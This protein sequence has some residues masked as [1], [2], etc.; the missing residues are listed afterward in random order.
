MKLTVLVDNNTTIDK[1]YF[2]E[3]GLSYYIEEEGKRLLFDVGYSDIFLRNASKM[4]IDLKKT[5]YLVLSH[6][7]LDHTW[8]MVNLFGILDYY[9]GADSL[10][11]TLLAHPGSLV[12]KIDKGEQIGFIY[13]RQMVE[14]AFN[15]NLTKKTVWITEKLVFLGEIE[16]TNDFENTEPIG[17]TLDNGV[18]V[19]DYIMDDTALAYK[20]RE[21]IVVITGCSHSGICNI[22]EY[23]KKV[24]GDDRVVDI[25]GGFHLLKPSEVRLEKTLA[26]MK[27]LAPKEVHT[28]HCTDLASKIS[29]AGVVNLKEVGV[30]EIFSY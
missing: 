13:S 17:I 22:V 2:G 12:T 6:G 10:R 7:H 23:A 20:T 1:N 21:G 9:S 30:G 4:G 8:G 15:L 26:Y 16:R 25:I 28:C 24:C 29:L 14:S 3:P 18:E 5:D 27:K 11:P 19:P